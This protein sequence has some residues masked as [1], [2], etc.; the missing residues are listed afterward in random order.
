MEQKKIKVCVYTR[1]S[2]KKQ[3]LQIQKD[4]IIKYCKFK[5]FEIV[6]MYEDKKTGKNIDRSGFQKMQKDLEI[7]PLGIEI[8]V[9]W[10][11]DR[12]GRSIRDLINITDFY[13][14]H[15]IGF[16]ATSSNIDTTTKEG[17][18]FFYMM[19]AIAEYERELIIE[20]TELGR[21]AAIEEGTKMG[22]PR[23]DL[24]LEKIRNLLNQ[25]ITKVRIAKDLKIHRTTLD[26]KLKE[27]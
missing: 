25:G 22:R 21:E 10:K 12:L 5:E 1:V 13:Q 9:V 11:L 18:L 3:D 26:K 2:T 16:V 17:R 15:N 23:Y 14:K 24:D 8:V 7:N 4:E 20:R 6:A 27:K 19:S